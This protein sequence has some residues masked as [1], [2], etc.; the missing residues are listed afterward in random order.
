MLNTLICKDLNN[1]DDCLT[2]KSRVFWKNIKCEQNVEVQMELL[3]KVFISITWTTVLRIHAHFSHFFCD[4]CHFYCMCMIVLHSLAT[5][6][7]TVNC[8]TPTQHQWKLLPFDFSFTIL[9][10]KVSG[11]S[12]NWHCAVVI[13]HFVGIL[14]WSLHDLSSHFYLF[15]YFST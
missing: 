11:I 9:A 6:L 5:S 15:C 7:S 10:Q 2:Y 13:W 8:C 3:F 1:D 14:S 12:F 4:P